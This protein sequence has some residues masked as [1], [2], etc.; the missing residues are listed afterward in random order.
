MCDMGND[1]SR[2]VCPLCGKVIHAGNHFYSA[3]G[4]SECACSVKAIKEGSLY[5]RA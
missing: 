5:G 2:L 3:S 1:A 4:A